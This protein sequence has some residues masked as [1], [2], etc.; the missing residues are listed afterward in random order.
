MSVVFSLVLKPAKVI[1]VLKKDSK[2]YCSNY[3]PIPLL[4]NK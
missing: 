1:P 3:C 4:S 2:L